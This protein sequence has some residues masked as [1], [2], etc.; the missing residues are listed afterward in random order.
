MHRFALYCAGALLTL[1]STTYA[2]TFQ[3]DT[4]P[5]AGTNVLNT[6]GRQIVG[7]EVSINFSIP[8]DTF[9]LEASVFG[10]AGPVNFV[11]ATAPLLPA[12]GVNVVV[13]QSF[14]DDANPLTPFGAGNA[15]NLIAD[16]IT[17]PGAGFF[18]YFNQGLDLPRLVYSTDLSD[19]SA[20]L[21]ILARML[22]LNGDAGRNA[23]PTFSEANFAI[24]T[25]APEPS[26]FFVILA[27][28]LAAGCYLV[29]RRSS[30]TLRSTAASSSSL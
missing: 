4:D 24:S 14:D 5:F 6:A 20:D 8:S 10:V 21:K 1:C 27:V 9:S 25:A 29:R 16:K 7:N 19:N 13:L 17:S 12:T 28:G 2:T 30:L 11:N 26:S 3:F 18:I 23:V 15:A 22:N